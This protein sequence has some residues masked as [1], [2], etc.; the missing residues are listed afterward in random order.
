[1]GFDFVSGAPLRIGVHHL[2][3]VECFFNQLLTALNLAL[4]EKVWGPLERFRP[5]KP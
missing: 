2:Q 5:G 4:L 1:M 3:L